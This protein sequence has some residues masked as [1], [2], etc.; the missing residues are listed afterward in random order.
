MLLAETWRL[1]VEL[2]QEQEAYG[3]MKQIKH[4]FDLANLLNPG[5]ILNNDPKIH[6]KQ[7]KLLPVA[8]EIIDKCIECRF[9]QVQ[10][11]SRD[12]SLS[13]RQR[14]TVWREITRL[15]TTGENKELQLE[16]R[17]LYH[18]DGEDTCATD[19]LCAMNCPVDI[20]AGKFD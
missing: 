12:L 16:L 11:P 7:I 17:Q 3:L 2:E 8:N 1:Y 6:V 9:C 13:P 4:L 10:C 14:I 19:A 20:D 15:T 5:V 18:Y